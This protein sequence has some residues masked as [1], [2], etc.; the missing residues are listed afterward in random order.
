MNNNQQSKQIFSNQGHNDYYRKKHECD[1]VFEKFQSVESKKIKL[2]EVA[3][4]FG[5]PD[6]TVRGWFNHWKE[7]QSWRPYDGSVHGFHHRIFSDNEE[8]SIADFIRSNYI[9]PGR[10]FQ[11]L[12]FQ[13]LA[14]QAFLEKYSG[15]DDHPEPMFSKKFVSNFKNRNGISSRKSRYRRRP[16]FPKE[17]INGWCDK[18]KELLRSKPVDRILN[19]DE[20][21]WR[22][23]PSSMSTWADK[24]SDS[25]K[26][27][28]EDD[29]KRMVTV[30]ATI[31]AAGTKLPLFMVAK[32]KTAAVES[33]QLGDIS[34]HMSTHSP[35]GWMEQE[36]FETYL[37]WLRQ[38]Y[39]DDAPLYLLVD[40][41]PVH[42]S[43]QSKALATSLNIE[44]FFVP[45][46]YT[47]TYQ[48]LDRR[49]FG[50]LK[51]TAKS[52]IHDILM[53]EPE[54]KIGTKRAIGILIWSWE[55]L[56]SDVL[57]DAWSIYYD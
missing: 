1:L 24:G 23:L 55:H 16:K 12:D 48:P 15:N 5:V 37:K 32:G 4:L 8:K 35:S 56:S 49:V 13:R 3:H 18:I 29:E 9:Q 42:C 31:T 46:G 57:N 51:S 34:Y 20:T 21:S 53:Q 14:S 10:L 19:G 47:D 43:Q 33:S 25:V 54:G 27:N 39:F 41:F 7:N 30:M 45:G 36:C 40:Q 26:I 28:V 22:I 38:Q 2:S 6:S 11:N 17:D 50:C 44:L 52:K